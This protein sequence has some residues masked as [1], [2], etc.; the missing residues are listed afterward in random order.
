MDEAIAQRAAPSN[1]GNPTEFEL[2]I[3]RRDIPM[4]AFS[5]P[6]D[7][8]N[9]HP[10]KQEPKSCD[11]LRSASQDAIGGRQLNISDLDMR[12]QSPASYSQESQPSPSWLKRA[13]F[14]WL[15]IY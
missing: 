6:P 11:A 14:R 13:L 15:E 7:P 10:S 9:T 12:A 4:P 8:G 5:P 3:P 1:D 2:R